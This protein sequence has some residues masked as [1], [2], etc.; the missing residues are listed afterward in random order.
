MFTLV[1]YQHNNL[2]ISEIL[3]QTA[4][5]MQ[6]QRSMEYTFSAP[7]VQTFWEYFLAFVQIYSIKL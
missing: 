1:Y 4:Y 7:D 6:S 2:P 3:G 5:W